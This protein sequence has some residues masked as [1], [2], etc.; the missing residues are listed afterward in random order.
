MLATNQRIIPAFTGVS[1]MSEMVERVAKAISSCISDPP[2]QDDFFDA[3]RAAIEAM[4]SVLDEKHD[5][6]S[7]YW[8][9]VDMIDAALKP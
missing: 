9:A 5:L 8:P 4:R 6:T 2:M 1:A 7:E 3:A